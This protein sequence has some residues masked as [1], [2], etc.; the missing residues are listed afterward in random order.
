MQDV[1]GWR[2]YRK[3]RKMRA[4]KSAWGLRLSRSC[5]HSGPVKRIRGWQEFSIT[6]IEPRGWLRSFLERQRDGLTG[7][8]EVAGYPFNTDGWL[9]D[10]LPR[11]PRTLA[12]WWPFEQY[13]YW[14][15]GMARCGLL[16]NDKKL[17]RRARR[18]IDHVL[19]RAD[20]DGY[21]GPTSLKNLHDSRRP[22]ERWP[23]AVFFRAITADYDA[24]P[25]AATLKALSRHYLSGTA[26]HDQTRNVCNVE[27]MAW[28]YEK[29]GDRRLLDEAARNYKS[30]QRNHPESG[31]TVKNMLSAARA[32]DHGPT[33]MELFKLGALLYRVTGR[34]RWLE[35]S[36]NAQKKLVRDHVLVDGI[37]STTEHLRGRYSNAGHETCVVTD[38]PWALGYLLMATGAAAYADGI[39]RAIFNA[40]P[41]SVTPDFKALQYFSGPNQVIACAGSNHHEHGRGGKQTTYRPNPATE[42][43]PGN[44]HR[45]MPNYIARMWLDDGRGGV[46]AA[47]YGPSAITV[48]SGRSALRIVQETNYPF[49]DRV[50]FHFEGRRTAPLRFTLRIPAWC[51]KAQLQL[52]GKVLKRA[53][54]PGSFVS[55]NRIFN[56]GDKLELRLPREWRFA[57][58]PEHGTSLE[59]GALVFAARIPERWQRDNADEKSSDKFPAWDLVPAQSWNYAIISAGTGSRTELEWVERPVGENPWDADETPYRVFLSVRSVPGWKLERLKKLEYE[60][61]GKKQFK[62][63][64]FAFTPK[65]PDAKTL[66]RA[67]KR[68]RRIELIPYGATR[69]RLAVLP[70][71]RE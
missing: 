12:S 35:A 15:D 53:L 40:L 44:I 56:D 20:K 23:H 30:F 66:G 64:D 58:G 45:A 70:R 55:V 14:V 47:C 17:L 65:L 36:I 1:W 59:W 63:G 32:K 52:N 24:R 41:G 13:A 9:R 50:A 4:Q 67:S 38:Y 68:T 21:L 49:D 2:K 25:V 28:L 71:V 26:R 16:L 57:P 62:R 18:Q 42:C 10:S 27:T 29:T 48:G 3:T 11:G 19:R 39:E 61:D 5:L 31:A 54:K 69:L 6:N 8:L 37:P 46:V 7:C 22:S 51:K 34:R 60:R 33:Y 43:C